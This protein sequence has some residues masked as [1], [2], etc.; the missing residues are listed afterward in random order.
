VAG[1]C[2]LSL[3]HIPPPNG[4]VTRVSNI[5]EYS[6]IAGW[7][8]S[9][10]QPKAL[11]ALRWLATVRPVQRIFC[12]KMAVLLIFYF[13]YELNRFVLLRNSNS[14]FALYKWVVIR[15]FTASTSSKLKLIRMTLS[16]SAN[17]DPNVCIDTAVIK[18]IPHIRQQGPDLVNRQILC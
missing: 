1:C 18:I 13:N 10:C 12:S 5:I 7:L 8:L 14:I 15:I 9:P 16:A 3:G 17:N 11:F 6:G 4:T 2:T